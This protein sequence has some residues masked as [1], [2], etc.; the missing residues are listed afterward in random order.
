MRKKTLKSAAGS[1]PRQAGFLNR[2]GFFPERFFV[3]IKGKRFLPFIDERSEIAVS[4]TLYQI[5]A[6]LSLPAFSHCAE[7][8]Y[9][10]TWYTERY[11][12]FLV[13][14]LGPALPIDMFLECRKTARYNLAIRIWVFIEFRSGSKRGFQLFYFIL[15]FL[16]YF[17]SR[18]AFRFFHNVLSIPR[19]ARTSCR[20]PSNHSYSISTLLL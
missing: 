6:G 9:I 10:R 14:C 7:F 5:V 19:A 13:N 20:L 15:I 11:H 18:H 16:L 3:F 1:A 12:D 2:P 8:F 4:D 17:S